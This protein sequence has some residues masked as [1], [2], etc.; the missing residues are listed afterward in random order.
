MTPKLCYKVALGTECFNFVSIIYIE[1]LHF[2]Y[3]EC[4]PD[5]S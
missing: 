1:Y 5:C 4:L 3:I 2:T